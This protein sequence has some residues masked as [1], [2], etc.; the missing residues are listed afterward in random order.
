M[1]WRRSRFQRRPRRSKS[2]WE[3]VS[4]TANARTV[5]QDMVLIKRIGARM[6]KRDGGMKVEW[7]NMCQVIGGGLPGGGVPSYLHLYRDYTGIGDKNTHLR[8]EYV[9]IGG[10]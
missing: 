7:G 6:E 2:F 10:H 5:W 9:K 3:L 1:K 4:T 8:K